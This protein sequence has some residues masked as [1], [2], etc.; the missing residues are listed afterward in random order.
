SA[1]GG[2]GGV[3]GVSASLASTVDM[4]WVLRNFTPNF[5]SFYGN[6]LSEGSRPIY[7]QGFYWGL[8]IEPFPKATLS[9]YYDFFR[10]PWLRYRVGAT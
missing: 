10:F 2:W 8:R 4:P 5:H 6:T 9:A 3:G 1:S 7:E